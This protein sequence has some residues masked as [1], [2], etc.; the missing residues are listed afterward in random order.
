MG[1]IISNHLSSCPRPSSSFATAE[2]GT[3]LSPLPVT[4][5]SILV[6]YMR[7]AQ[8]NHRIFKRRRG[9]QERGRSSGIGAI[10]HDLADL[11]KEETT[12]QWR[13]QLA[14]TGRQGHRFS[15]RASRR[16]TP[17][18]ANTLMVAPPDLY[19]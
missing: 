14:A 18:P 4:E 16:N 17:Y 13:W 2:L 3:H 15:A 10:W 19:F 7:W 12:S 9:R 1:M 5:I 6:V 11:E 8:Y